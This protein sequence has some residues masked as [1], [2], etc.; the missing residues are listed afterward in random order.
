MAKIYLAIDE[1]GAEMVFDEKPFQE[2]KI[3]IGNAY[4]DRFRSHNNAIQLPRGTIEKIIGY[5][6]TWADEPVL[7]VVE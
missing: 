7:V 2:R 5:E 6:I 4:V 3:W 1:D